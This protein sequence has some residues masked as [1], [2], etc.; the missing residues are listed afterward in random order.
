MPALLTNPGT[1]RKNTGGW[2]D[3]GLDFAIWMQQDSKGKEFV[4]IDNRIFKLGIK[5][6]DLVSK[7]I[8]PGRNFYIERK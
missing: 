6:S 1:G 7:K 2:V 4:S 8:L 3:P 5:G